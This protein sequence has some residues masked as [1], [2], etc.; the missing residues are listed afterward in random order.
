MSIQV[1]V[2]CTVVLSFTLLFPTLPDA[3][4][5]SAASPWRLS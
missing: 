5:L 2:A 1:T 4:S 3:D